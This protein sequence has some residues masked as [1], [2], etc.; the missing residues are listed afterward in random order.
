MTFKKTSIPIT[1]VVLLVSILAVTFAQAGNVSSRSTAQK[2]IAAVE[3]MPRV[4]EPLAV[5]D[6][7]AISKFYYERILDLNST[8]DSFPVVQVKADEAG[9]RMKS[10]VGAKIGGEGISCLS[11]VVGARLAG[12][13]PRHFRGINYLWRAKAWYDPVHGLYRHAVGERSPV[14]HSGIYGYWN[15]V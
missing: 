14:V 9:F 1:T 2:T 3:R 11:A 10:Y 8:G 6:W 7:R 12:L 15:A 4:P 5:R 13:D